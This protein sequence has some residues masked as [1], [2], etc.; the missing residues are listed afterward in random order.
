MRLIPVQGSRPSPSPTTSQLSESPQWTVTSARKNAGKKCYVMVGLRR[1]PPRHP[2]QVTVWRWHL[3]HG[4]PGSRSVHWVSGG[5]CQET[6]WSRTPA[7][8]SLHAERSTACVFSYFP[9]LLPLW[10][11]SLGSCLSTQREGVQALQ[12]ERPLGQGVS[13][14]GSCSCK[15]RPS[16]HWSLIRQEASKEDTLCPRAGGTR[17]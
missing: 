3:I 4:R 11:S 9:N 5:W 6:R 12:K 1:Q 14:Q 10:R 17:R 2:M 15:E 16:N 8:S 7:T 13:C